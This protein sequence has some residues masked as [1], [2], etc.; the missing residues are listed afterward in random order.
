MT[1][2]KR[3]YTRRNPDT[4]PGPVRDVPVTQADE[5]QSAEITM[6]PNHVQRT[7]QD[8]EQRAQTLEAEAAE[9]RRT[10]VGLREM[11]GMDKS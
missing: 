8:L 10:A 2:Q 9:M 1:K 6:T 7:I 5:N 3:K 11:F 4:K